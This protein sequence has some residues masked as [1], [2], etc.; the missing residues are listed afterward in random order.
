MFWWA[1]MSWLCAWAALV[2]SA[3]TVRGEQP[4]LARSA[5]TSC[6]TRAVAADAVAPACGALC[7]GV[8]VAVGAVVAFGVVEEPPAV[9]RGVAVVCAGA[10]VLCLGAVVLGALCLGALC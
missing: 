7:E 9:C 1:A 10:V 3:F 8:A 4:T 5:L 2:R 6:T